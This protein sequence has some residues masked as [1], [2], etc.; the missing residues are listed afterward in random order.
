M[1][2]TIYSMEGCQYCAKIIQVL[3]LTEQKYVE[4]KLN[5]DFTVEEF[6]D[7]FPEGTS[8]PQVLVDYKKIGGCSDTIRYL[9]EQNIL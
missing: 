4:Y 1:M 2:F 7:E 6:Y 5:R 8:F 9:K 3:Q